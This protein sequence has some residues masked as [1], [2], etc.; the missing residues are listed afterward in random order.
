V[1]CAFT[2]LCAGFSS[3]VLVSTVVALNQGMPF[4]AITE[5]VFALLA[6]GR[7]EPVADWVL[8]LTAVLGL[9]CGYLG[10]FAI[11]NRRD[12]EGGFRTLLAPHYWSCFHPRFA[13]RRGR[14]A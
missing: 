9:V 12:P 2:V 10:F 5:P 3:R 4:S 6:N 11:A 14:G 8:Y 7:I 13:W 1:L